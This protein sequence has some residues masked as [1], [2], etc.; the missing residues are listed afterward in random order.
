MAGSEK[1]EKLAADEDEEVRQ[2]ADKTVSE[3]QLLQ[4][5]YFAFSLS[6]EVGL[7]E[8]LNE[9]DLHEAY[10]ESDDSEK[11]LLEEKADA[12]FLER[13]KLALEKYSAVLGISN[14]MVKARVEN[15][16]GFIFLAEASLA[17]ND[18]IFRRI[19][20]LTN[21]L[22]VYE[23]TTICL[24]GYSSGE[25][26]TGSFNSYGEEYSGICLELRENIIQAGLFPKFNL[27]VQNVPVWRILGDYILRYEN[28]H[29]VFDGIEIVFGNFAMKEDD[30][31]EEIENTDYKVFDIHVDTQTDGSVTFYGGLENCMDL[32]RVDWDYIRYKYEEHIDPDADIASTLSTLGLTIAEFET[33]VRQRF[34]ETLIAK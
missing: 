29:S 33:S 15:N 26:D 34:S 5:P 28:G 3:I 24:Q 16:I 22:S 10:E 9:N 13:L 2:R 4:F 21:D 27:H 25:Y 12:F 23:F 18:H 7:E 11:H 19:S 31:G 32:A 1:L 20:E 30:D 14:G 17:A 8:W 6:G